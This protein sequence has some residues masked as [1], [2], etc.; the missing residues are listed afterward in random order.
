MSCSSQ[1]FRF[2]FVL[3]PT[4]TPASVFLA[5]RC[6]WAAKEEIDKLNQIEVSPRAMELTESICKRI[7]SDGGGALIIDYGLD[8]VV[9]DSLQVQISYVNPLLMFLSLYVMIFLPAFI[10]PCALRFLF[11]NC[12]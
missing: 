12:Y 9:S 2:R 7:G 8:G 1:L 6:K 4:P 3:S 10:I 11:L 5:K